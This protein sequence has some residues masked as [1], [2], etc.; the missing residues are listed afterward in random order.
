MSTPARRSSARAN[1]RRDR[2]AGAAD[3]SAPLGPLNLRGVVDMYDAGIT[4]RVGGHRESG[5]PAGSWMGSPAGSWPGCRL[6][7]RE[8]PHSSRRRAQVRRKSSCGAPPAQPGWI[9]TPRSRRRRARECARGPHTCP[10]ARS[11]RLPQRVCRNDPA[12]P[13]IAV[14]TSGTRSSDPH[15]TLY[16]QR[17]A[18][19]G[20]T[21]EQ[22]TGHRS[23]RRSAC[24]RRAM[25]L[26]G[27][28]RR[29][30]SPTPSPT[31]TPRWPPSK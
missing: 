31:I 7:G 23:L 27:N 13:R 8:A 21:L 25:P 20:R 10:N 3:E 4:D 11:P 14:S 9:K 29:W 12:G 5:S 2:S 1:S 30:P 15:Q 17:Q 24:R 22:R 26:A 28:R 6:R 18:V 19:L 16:P